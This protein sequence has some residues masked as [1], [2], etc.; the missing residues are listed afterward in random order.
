MNFLAVL[1]SQSLIN[2]EYK[3]GLKKFYFSLGQ[4][5]Q[6]NSN[7]MVDKE[8]VIECEVNGHK[9]SKTKRPERS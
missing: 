7:R 5:Y 4:K 2:G 9:K 8:T 3:F 6:R 1:F